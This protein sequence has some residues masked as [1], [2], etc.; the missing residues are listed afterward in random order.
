MGQEVKERIEQTCHSKHSAKKKRMNLRA[1]EKQRVKG[2]LFG[3]MFFKDVYRPKG[4]NQN[5]KQK[6]TT[7]TPKKNL[8]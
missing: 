8:E 5:K 6:K 1:R 4:R 3:L 2:G 7:T